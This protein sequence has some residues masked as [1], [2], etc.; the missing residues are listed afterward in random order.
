MSLEAAVERGPKHSSMAMPSFYNNSTR[1]FPTKA[2]NSQPVFTSGKRVSQLPG[3][4]QTGRAE[5]RG[6]LGFTSS[7]EEDERMK[8]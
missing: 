2:K 7:L 4:V 1:P 3:F 8:T 5:L 6:W